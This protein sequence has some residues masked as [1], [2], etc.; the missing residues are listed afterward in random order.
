MF[1]FGILIHNE[2][3]LSIFESSM[4]GQDILESVIL[5]MPIFIFN[6][7][8]INFLITIPCQFKM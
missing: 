8:E 3:N 7:N 4:K 6:K 2:N 5:K 1:C